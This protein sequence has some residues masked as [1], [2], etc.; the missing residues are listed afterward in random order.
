M[1]AQIEK[2]KE[3]K[4]KTVVNSVVQKKGLGKQWVGFVGNRP[5]AIA[6]RKS[7]NSRISTNNQQK[8]TGPPVITVMPRN[9]SKNSVMQKQTNIAHVSR[10]L[11]WGQK[12]GIVGQ[13]VTAYLDPAYRKVGTA[14]ATSAD[15]Y[16]DLDKKAALYNGG[17]WARGHLLNHDLGGK[18]KTFNLY[19]ITAGANRRHSENVEQEV[20]KLLK[21]EDDHRE[22]NP[23]NHPARVYYQVLATGTPDDSHFLCT[24]GM[25]KRNVVDVTT[26]EGAATKIK[27][28]S[29]LK[30]SEGGPGGGDGYNNSQIIKQ[31]PTVGLP[32]WK[33]KANE[34]NPTNWLVGTDAELRSEDNGNTQDT[35]NKAGIGGYQMAHPATVPLTKAKQHQLAKKRIYE[36]EATRLF[37]LCKVSAKKLITAR[38]NKNR[39]LIDLTRSP[40]YEVIDNS[41]TKY[42]RAYTAKKIT[43][44]VKPKIAKGQSYKNELLGIK[45]AATIQTTEMH[46]G[47]LKDLQL[48]TDTIKPDKIIP[49]DLTDKIN[50]SYKAAGMSI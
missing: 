11:K 18:G 43:D 32:A 21:E 10:T 23:T 1:Y 13:S 15:D 34:A 48:Y 46:K 25:T 31:V 39:N 30:G 20:K 35:A 7:I 2:P 49:N 12:T 45:A 41:G 26:L 14:T 33:H 28:N 17:N 27:I 42:M 44:D 47:F 36:A 4:S 6:Q 38:Y 40:L 5:E 50:N 19:P 8:P 37:R 3:D 29:K 24:Y 16:T 22:T 9:S